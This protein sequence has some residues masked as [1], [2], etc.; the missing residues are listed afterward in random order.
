VIVLKLLDFN[1]DFEIDSD[2]SN[3]VIGGILVQKGRLV[4]FESKKLSET[5]RRWAN[6]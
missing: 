4:A 1:K 3:F 5:K 2:A 6:T